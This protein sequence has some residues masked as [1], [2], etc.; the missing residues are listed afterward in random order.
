MDRDTSH[1]G[2][3]LARPQGNAAFNSANKQRSPI[4]PKKFRIAQAMQTGQT[5]HSRRPPQSSSSTITTSV[6]FNHGGASQQISMAS[7]SSS[8]PSASLR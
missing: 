6:D 5:K 2:T 4:E 7:L 8:T 3:F 1:A